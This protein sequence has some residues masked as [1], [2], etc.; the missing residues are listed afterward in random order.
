MK[1]VAKDGI[2]SKMSQCRFN[3]FTSSAS[4]QDWCFLLSFSRDFFHASLSYYVGEE[5]SGNV[6]A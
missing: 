5:G 1:A 6:V 2:V 4:R 3:C